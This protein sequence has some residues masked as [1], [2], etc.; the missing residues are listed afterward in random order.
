MCFVPAPDGQPHVAHGM[1]K[2]FDVAKAKSSLKPPT[3][4]VADVTLTDSAITFPTGN[5][6]RQRDAQGDQQRHRPRTASRW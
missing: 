6:G 1:V 4:G 5:L 3:D 2:M